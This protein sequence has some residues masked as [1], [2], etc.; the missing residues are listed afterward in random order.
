ML[1]MLTMCTGRTGEALRG[2]VKQRGMPA[3]TYIRPNVIPESMSDSVREGNAGL[4][5]RGC[6]GGAGRGCSVLAW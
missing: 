6:G 2:V 1:T 5:R 3:R 4:I